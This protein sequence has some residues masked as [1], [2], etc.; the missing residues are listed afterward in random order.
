MS[1]KAETT[2]AG[3]VRAADETPPTALTAVSGLMDE[4]RRYDSWLAGLEARRDTTPPRVFARVHADYTT[5]LEGVVAQL[6]TH[7]EALRGELKR[8]T[9]Q[10]ASLHEEQQHARDERA[11]AELRAHVGEL[12]A[13]AWEATARAADE[14]IDALVRR[15]AELE[16]ELRR[17]RELLA[18]AE[19][20]ATPHLSS[21]AVPANAAVDAAVEASVSASVNAAAAH[22]TPGAVQAVGDSA[23]AAMHVP[24]APAKPAAADTSATGVPAELPPA[25]ISAEAA[26]MDAG[27]GPGT[28]PGDARRGTASFDEL[29]FL[30]SV[31]DTPAAP[32]ES[33]APIREEPARSEAAPVRREAYTARPRETGIENLDATADTSILNKPTRQ[34]TP[35]AANISGNNPIVLRDKSA[36]N[37][38]TL[39]CADCGAMNYPTEWY[40]E[41]CGAELASL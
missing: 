17:T 19:R 40:C 27:E 16:T 38:K 9:T 31:V 36:E 24:S 5:R 4:R 20:P 14:R 32:G 22:P 41:R 6:V 30:N 26:L 25:V 15:H 12:S 21:K 29:A 37:A 3:S 18:D 8:L 10:L 39:K 23:E 7:V 2:D 13:E 28:K 33:P 35:M 11:E 34:G 1:K